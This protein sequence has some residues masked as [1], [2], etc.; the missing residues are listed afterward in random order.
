MLIALDHNN[1]YDKELISSPRV[2]KCHCYWQT[3]KHDRKNTAVGATL[4]AEIHHPTKL[5]DH[6]T[7]LHCLIHSMA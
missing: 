1:V 3:D 5:M 7:N 6:P 4:S 2:L